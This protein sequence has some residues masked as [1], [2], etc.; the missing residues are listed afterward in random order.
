[1]LRTIVSFV[2]AALA[3]NLGLVLLVHAESQGSLGSTSQGDSTATIGVPNL[4]LISGV[5]DLNFGSYSGGSDPERN[6]RVC[7]YTNNGTGNYKVKALGN[8]TEA[9]GDGTGFFARL[10]TFTATIPYSVQ[11]NDESQD[12]GQTLTAG[13]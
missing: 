8:Y 5:A 11:W 7:V 3:S 2:F 9:G 12:G 1:M 13:S 10:G 6:E 4:I